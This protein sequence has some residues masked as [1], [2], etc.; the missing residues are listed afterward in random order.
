MPKLRISYRIY[1]FNF[2]CMTYPEKVPAEGID[3]N[4]NETNKNHICRQQTISECSNL[5]LNCIQ[6]SKFLWLLLT[7]W[8]QRKEYRIFPGTL[9]G[10]NRSTFLLD[11]QY[12]GKI[13]RMTPTWKIRQRI[14]QYRR[15]TIG[16]RR[17]VH[18]AN[19]NRN[20]N[21]LSIR[22]SQIRCVPEGI[23]ESIGR[24]RIP[25]TPIVLSLNLIPYW[26][27]NGRMSWF[28][29]NCALFEIWVQSKDVL[30]IQMECFS[31]SLS[32]SSALLLQFRA[33][34]LL[35]LLSLL[36]L[37]LRIKYQFNLSNLQASINQ[38]RKIIRKMCFTDKSIAW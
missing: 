29:M 9:F 21:P 1:D 10:R 30:A 15:D 2:I 36:P 26:P 27:G 35:R 19:R 8:C 5:W 7:A 23:I 11:P 12:D 16:S 32:S 25:T 22:C 33:L 38:R 17:R 28:P 4:S 20:H 18:W 6:R 13:C 37:L 34:L 31:S 24:R 14:D 3:K